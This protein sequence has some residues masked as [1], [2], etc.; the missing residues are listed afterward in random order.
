MGLVHI[1]GEVKGPNGSAV[2][3]FLVDTGA[4]FTLILEAIWREI[5]L[6]AKRA[7]IFSLAD[8]SEIRRNISECQIRLLEDEGH[9]PVIMGEG[10]DEALL[11]VVTLEEFGLMINPFNRQL[12]PMRMM[13]AQSVSATLA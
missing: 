1:E 6:V 5:G 7:M 8:G 3:K 11:G 10:A 12:Q 4:G 13:L 2:V 9:T